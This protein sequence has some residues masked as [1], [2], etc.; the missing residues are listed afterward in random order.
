MNGRAWHGGVQSSAL[1]TR[2]LHPALLCAATH[3]LVPAG[4]PLRAPV[5]IIAKARGKCFLE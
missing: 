2:A 5:T 3:T 1:A 4:Y